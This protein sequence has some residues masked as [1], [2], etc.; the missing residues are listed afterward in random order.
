M[1]NNH[2]VAETVKAVAR[3]VALPRLCE[4][5]GHPP[6]RTRTAAEYESF[7]PRPRV[8]NLTLRRLSEESK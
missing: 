1:H 6:A 4:H 7:E 3:P 8:W 5:T 2:A